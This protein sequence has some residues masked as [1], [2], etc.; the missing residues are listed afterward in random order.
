MTSLQGFTPRGPLAGFARS[1]HS[2][3]GE[4]GIIAEILHRIGTERATKWCVEFGAW[5]GVALSNACRLIRE[6]GYR[7][8]L[9][10]AKRSRFVELLKNHPSD[11]VIKMG[12]LVTSVGPDRLDALLSRTAIPKDFDLLSVDIDGRDY[13][14]WKAVTA[15][16]PKVVCME[17]NFSIPNDV[18]FVQVDDGRVQQGA[19]AK[20]LCRLA[21][22]KGYVPVAVTETNLIFVRDDLA[23]DVLGD[24]RP[25]ID[26]LRDDSAWR[27]SVFAGYDGSLHFSRE[28]YV[29]PWHGWEIRPGDIQPLPRFLRLYAGEYSRLRKAAYLFLLAFHEPKEF[30]RWCRRF[31]LRKP[32]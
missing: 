11:E 3:F 23:H 25:T 6:D 19:S 2:Q 15:Y 12:K 5:D 13:H 24:L 20:S 28:P 1:V 9:I 10:E 7:A 29:L 22:E 4:D 18:E 26:E 8:V 17:Y 32:D 31:I 30:R 21:H 16:M 14:V 27:V